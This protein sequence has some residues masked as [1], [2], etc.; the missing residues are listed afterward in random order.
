MCQSLVAPDASNIMDGTKEIAK[1]V[2]K[3]DPDLV[4]RCAVVIVSLQQ[5]DG[6]SRVWFQIVFWF[7]IGVLGRSRFRLVLG[8]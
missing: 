8:V 4:D 2:I 3:G 1:K 6:G 5:L 7:Q